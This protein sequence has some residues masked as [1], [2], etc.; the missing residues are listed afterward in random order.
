[1]PRRRLKDGL[2]PALP[3]S[4]SPRTGRRHAYKCYMILIFTA[5]LL[6]QMSPAKCSLTSSLHLRSLDDDIQ[7]MTSNELTSLAIETTLDASDVSLDPTT[8]DQDKSK[9]MVSWSNAH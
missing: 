9:R 6:A 8:Q 1:M 3:F 2:E 4:T 5:T 7:Q